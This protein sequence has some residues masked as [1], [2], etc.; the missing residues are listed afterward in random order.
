M[1]VTQYQQYLADKSQV[2]SDPEECCLAMG[3]VVDLVNDTCDLPNGQIDLIDSCGFAQEV[4]TNAP[5]ANQQQS[6]GGIGAWLSENLETLTNIG[7]QVGTLFGGTPP[8]P[9][10]MTQQEEDDEGKN[11]GT[12]IA[13]AVAILV[14][15]VAIVLIR[16]KGK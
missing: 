5:D 12:I 13:V 1:A 11:T 3:G 7:M 6:G 9:P 16:K 14:V 8:P 2:A 15:V 10:G 4:A